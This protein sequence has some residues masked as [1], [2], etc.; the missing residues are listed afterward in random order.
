MTESPIDRAAGAASLDT[1]YW[2]GAIFTSDRHMRFG[3]SL[4]LLLYLGL[5][6]VLLPVQLLFLAV[7]P[8]LARRLPR[9]H[10]RLTT[11]IIGMRVVCAGRPAEEPGTLFV[12]NHVSYFDIIALG[13]V[14]DAHFVAKSEVSGWPLF[15]L[16]AKLS[17]TVFIERRGSR[18]RRQI[19]QLW[20]RLE[21]GERLIIFP[22]GTSSDGSRVLPFKSSLF[23]AVERKD[24]IVQP[25]SIRYT[26][27][28]GMPLGRALR[29]LYAW[30]GA[31]E[32]VPHLLEALSR[33]SI[34]VTIAF[35]PLL[36]ASDFPDRKGL[37]RHCH[38][39][40]ADG[41]DPG[42]RQEPRNR[43]GS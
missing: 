30:Y 34:E 3:A 9:L 39:R 8:R 31:M 1:S 19:D 25:V 22:E 24:A 23:G 20:R 4:R 43:L 28:N 21:N 27:I 17:G 36:C 11:R 10:H 13:S 18:A 26:R 12:S 16:L 6:L 14:L 35:H 15:G 2:D 33:G 5:T 29:P 32:L 37:S 41:V 42:A 40:V 38:A 7:T